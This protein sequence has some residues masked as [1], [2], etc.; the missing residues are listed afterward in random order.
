MGFSFEIRM[1]KN[2]IIIKLYEAAVLKITDF[3]WLNF[4]IV[5][6]L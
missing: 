5:N 3:V 1:Q 2:D 6:L 4:C